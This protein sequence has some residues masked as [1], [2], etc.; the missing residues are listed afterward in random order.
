MGGAKQ[1]C[2]SLTNAPSA[3]H[4]S[5][6]P[7]S[8]W[9][10]AF[11]G[12]E[13]ATLCYALV[14]HHRIATTASGDAMKLPIELARFKCPAARDWTLT[15]VPWPAYSSATGTAW[16]F[17]HLGADRR[18]RSKPGRFS[19]KWDGTRFARD[20]DCE[21]ASRTAPDALDKAHAVLAAAI[22]RQ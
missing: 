12:I 5:Q 2:R 11:G 9:P 7:A 8:C 18:S 13:Y 16:W 14:Y 17:V 20:K 22:P 21:R 6:G 3:G 4:I 10:F 19:L 1:L 15:V